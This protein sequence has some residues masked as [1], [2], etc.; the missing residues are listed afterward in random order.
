MV[1]SRP[2]QNRDPTETV[3]D[4]IDRLI[5]ACARIQADAE[6]LLKPE[7]AWAVERV[8]LTAIINQVPELLYAK[9]LKGRFVAAN[10]AV[11][12]DNG[13]QRAE[14]VIGKTDFD[15]H[16]TDVAKGFFEIEQR[17]MASGQPMIDMEERRTDGPG[18][19]K[20]LLT[21]KVPM[22]GGRG[23][24]VGLIG[25]ARNITE[26]KRAEQA[27]KDERALY[28]AM[29]DQVPDYL[30]AKDIE[31][32]FVVANRA[33]AA[34]VGLQADDLI[35]KTDFQL[36]TP[37]L[38]RKF[39]TDEQ[40][41][42]R[43]REPM[44]DIEEFVVDTAGT[45][46]WLS[47]SKVPLRNDQHEVIGIVGIARDVTDRK[48]AEEKIHFMAHHDALTGL[49]NRILLMDRLTQ[50]LL[51]AKRNECLVTVIF[52]DLDNFKL[53]N[54]SF[55]HDAGDTLLKT[56]AER[57]VGC[58]RASDTVV[59]LGGD[60]FVVLLVHQAD[61][62]DVALVVLEKIRAALAE[63]I[64]IGGQPFRLTCSIGLANYPFDGA[65]AETLLMNADVA[66]YQAKEKGRNNFQYYTTEMDVAAH[67]KR[68][69]Q[70]GLRTGLA[71]NEFALVYQ[72]QVDLQSG[73]IF[74]AEALVRWHHP[75]LG[76]ISPAQFIPMAEE[77]GLIVPLGDWVLREA[78]RQNQAWQ[79]TGM[80]PI[81]VCVN[82]SARQFRDMNWAERVAQVLKETGLEPRYLELELTE[83]L[84]MQDVRHTIATMQELQAIGV[85]FA[86]DDFGTGYSSLSAL[87]SFPVA[88]LKIDKSFVRNLPNDPDDCSIASAVI[89]LGHSL[90]M[91][92]IAE[93]V[94]TDAQLAFLT[95]KNCD[96]IQ[97]YR[98]S[99]PVGSEAMGAMLR[100][101][102]GA[103]AGLVGR[104]AV[105]GEQQELSF[106]LGHRRASE[107]KAAKRG[108]RTA[109]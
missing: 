66:M 1:E 59:R 26:R 22:K 105:V 80:P 91:K 50:A 33:V 102:S 61:S 57:M 42:I 73:R 28:R 8:L 82:V 49:P 86:I 101:Q 18:G 36:H 78:C 29:I 43:S 60:E 109:L 77:S 10:D 81:T 19:T 46:K 41:V 106:G 21:T 97:G 52:M 23:E 108:I 37:E 45:R 25:V 79:D 69:L 67:A 65:D 94:E 83:S 72:P 15:L 98:F 16:P 103:M 32:R 4:Q 53:V 44:I 64:Q 75:E 51:M 31:S 54:D 55:G 88:R 58:V 84:L 47:T 56:V 76:T 62:P 9:D 95:D 27:W 39:F 71:R 104:H 107:R 5:S 48:R 12:R 90:N 13:L 87:K 96:E 92:V 99:K 24:I 70:E 6:R 2:R 74:S 14:D 11:A 3:H 20:W 40:T 68:T 17:I 34:D 35:G 63:P 7:P 100:K 93:G 89:S 30:F 38:A 85:R